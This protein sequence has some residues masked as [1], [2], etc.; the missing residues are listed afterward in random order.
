LK[1]P[2][3]KQVRFESDAFKLAGDIIRRQVESLGAY[4]PALKLIAR[5]I[6]SSFGQPRLD[7]ACIFGARDRRRNGNAQQGDGQ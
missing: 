6:L 2:T 3:P 7:R 1:R 5:Q 4:A